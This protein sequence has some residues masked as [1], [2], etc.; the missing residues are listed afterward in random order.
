MSKAIK[1]AIVHYRVGRTDGVS[2]E[3]DKRKSILQMLGHQVKL[4]SGPIQNGSDFIID[5]LEFDLPKIR[6]IKE[7]SFKYFAQN[8]LDISILFPINNR[9][10]NLHS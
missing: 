7:N 5:E 8:T 1:I 3:I 9:Q 4:I 6:E 2:L 10:N